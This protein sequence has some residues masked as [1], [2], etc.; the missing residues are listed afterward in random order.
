MKAKALDVH[1]RQAIEREAAELRALHDHPDFRRW[2]EPPPE[3]WEKW[4]G[5]TRRFHQYVPP[6]IA[7]VWR[8]AYEVDAADDPSLRRRVFAYLA[9]DPVHFWSGYMKQRLLRKV[10]RWSLEPAERA[11]MHDV[12]LRQVRWPAYASFRDA[13][14]TIPTVGDQTLCVALLGLTEDHDP[15]VAE[16]AE[17]A[18]NYFGHDQR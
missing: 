3:A 16:R 7:D 18:L 1:L 10:K 8:A 17:I 12:I 11:I 5:A 2:K 4:R 9:V 15:D 14:R 13:L 6:L